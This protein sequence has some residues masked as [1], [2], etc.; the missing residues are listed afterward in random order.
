MPNIN[1]KRSL[2]TYLKHFKVLGIPVY[3]QKDLASLFV[4]WQVCSGEDWTIKRMKSLKVDLIR[5]KANLPPLTW[6]RKNR[7]GDIWGPLGSLF[8]WSEKSDKN[9]SKA[10][11][12]LMAYTQWVYS[13][14]TDEQ[15]KKFYDAV[16]AEKTDID[17]LVLSKVSHRAACLSF[18]RVPLSL[19]QSI[20]QYQGSPT[21]RAPMVFKG[22][23]QDEQIFNEPENLYNVS[24]NSLYLRYERL[25]RPLLEGFPKVRQE[26]SRIKGN[27]PPYCGKIAF[28][29]EPG[30][31]LRSVAS[32]F[33]FIQK[34]LEPLS[35][36]LYGIAE[37][38]P[39]DCTFDQRKAFPFI[40]DALSKGKTVHSIDLSSFTDYFPLQLQ[41]DVMKNLVSS[42]DYDYVRLWEDFCKGY[43]RL[44]SKDVIQWKRGQPLGMLPSFAIATITH[45]LLL[46]SLSQWDKNF[47]VLGDDVIILDDNLFTLYLESLQNLG[48]PISKEKSISSNKL[49]EFAGKLILPS[50]IVP[51]MKWRAISDDNFLDLCRL[52]G[53]RIRTILR[54]RQK[55]VF[56]LIRHLPEPIGLNHSLPNDNYLKSMERFFKSPFFNL[57]KIVPP[58]LLGLRRKFHSYV[59]NCDLRKTSIISSE[60]IENILSSFDEKVK[61]VMSQTIFS[62]WIV[63][64]QMLNAFDTLPGNLGIQG[65]P[66]LVK[67]PSKLS[68]L[69]RYERVLNV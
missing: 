67:Q 40:Q 7:R 29:Q 54:P 36:H 24:N 31:K 43:W 21:K 2:G 42:E 50:L 17:P 46:D 37:S 58:S 5:R 18:H 14:I 27:P 62:S 63:V 59:Y 8:R 6:L 23:P 34:V 11:Q 51:Q 25:F 20:L 30:G 57:E 10:I 4:K 3:L 28:I 64:S 16:T 53:H 41:V 35:D 68:T 1:V 45:G 39:W 52:L 61:S 22:V 55:K 32:P 33:R 69:M 44:P 60:E 38:L 48:C 12:V 47:F 49:A 19:P 15:F 13:S 56:D 66:L 9:F 26:L 65:L